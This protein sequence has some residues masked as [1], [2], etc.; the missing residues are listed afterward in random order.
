MAL[1]PAHHGQ[2]SRNVDSAV[3]AW[4]AANGATVRKRIRLS[5]PG[6][7]SRT[8]V[9]DGPHAL[10]LA[11]Q[12]EAFILDERSANAEATIHLFAAMPVGLAVLLGTRLNRC[13][14]I[15]CYEYVKNT[16]QPSCWLE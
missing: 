10:A 3:G 2:I 1:R 8:S 5:L 7:S 16:Y 14:P 15:Q 4:L 12:I 9:D 11:Y 6:G 13:G